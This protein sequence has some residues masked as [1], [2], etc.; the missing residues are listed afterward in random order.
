M[1]VTLIRFLQLIILDLVIYII[2]INYFYI[3]L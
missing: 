2:L 3:F 1:T